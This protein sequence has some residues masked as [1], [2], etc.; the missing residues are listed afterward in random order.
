MNLFLCARLEVHAGAVVWCSGTQ[1][2]KRKIW[3]NQET[4]PQVL[5]S[6][7]V[8][9]QAL[10]SPPPTNQ[11]ALAQLHSPPTTNSPTFGGGTSTWTTMGQSPTRQHPLLSPLWDPKK[12]G[13]GSV[14]QPSILIFV[15]R[16]QISFHENASCFLASISSGLITNTCR[17]TELMSPGRQRW[18]IRYLSPITIAMVPKGL[19]VTDGDLYLSPFSLSCLQ[20]RGGVGEGAADAGFEGAAGTTADAGS[21]GW[22]RVLGW[23]I[24]AAAHNHHRVVCLPLGAR[25]PRAADSPS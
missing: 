15:I 16:P 7:V 11:Q 6:G 24:T 8:R 12:C 17:R 22:F 2:A 3:R 10:S 25:R 21:P 4:H 9:N 13:D 19:A 20:S 5:S 1:V 23:L 14:R 18:S